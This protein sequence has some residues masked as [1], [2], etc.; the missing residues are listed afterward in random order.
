MHSNKPLTSLK[1][2]SC[3]SPYN[4]EKTP[5]P[6]HTS[7]SNTKNDTATDKKNSYHYDF[8]HQELKKNEKFQKNDPVR[9]PNSHAEGKALPHHSEETEK[10]RKSRRRIC[11]QPN[12]LPLAKKGRTS[13]KFSRRF[14]PQETSQRWSEP[15][16]HGQESPSREIRRKKDSAE[17]KI[18]EYK[19]QKMSIPKGGNPSQNFRDIHQENASMGELNHDTNHKCL[20]PET[21]ER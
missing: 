14:P 20:L 2:L 10:K 6:S 11:S 4:K 8:L 16:C 18:S 17:R 3:P 5:T 9:K 7:S 12:R 15:R 13:Q 19:H 21:S 1:S